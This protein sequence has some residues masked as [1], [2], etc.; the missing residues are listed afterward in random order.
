MYTASLF[1]YRIMGIRVWNVLY[2]NFRD[3]Y[4]FLFFIFFVGMNC[5]FGFLYCLTGDLLVEMG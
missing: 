5:T 4:I 1:S 3:D 2:S